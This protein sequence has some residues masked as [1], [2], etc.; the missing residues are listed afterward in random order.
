MLGN[1]IADYG[2]TYLQT[3]AQTEITK[4]NLAAQTKIIQAQQ[5]AALATYGTPNAYAALAA[6]QAYQNAAEVV[7]ASDNT[8]YWILGG[9]GLLGLVLMMRK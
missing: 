6:T 9:V 3:K 7:P 5:Q 8:V 4:L 1:T 2:K